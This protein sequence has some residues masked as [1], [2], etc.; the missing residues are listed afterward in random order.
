MIATPDVIIL[1]ADRID[2]AQGPLSPAEQALIAQAHPRRR[3]QFTAGRILAHRALARAGQPDK[4]LLAD[5][6][7]CPIWPDGIT[8]SIS[9][10]DT[11]CVA[12]VAPSAEVTSLGIDIEH[13][14]RVQP[15]LWPMLFTEREQATLAKLPETSQQIW[16]GCLFSIK[17]AFYKYQYPLTQRMVGFKDVE[18]EGTL[19]QA[20]ATICILKLIAPPLDAGLC[21]PSQHS[22]EKDRVCSLVYG[23]PGKSIIM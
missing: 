23:T 3:R 4:P 5:E 1:E 14:S 6:H 10:T 19:T 13:P 8:G 17:E 16:A 22:L 18:I 9:H 12:A 20:T 7:R 11:W 21:L 15:N 2:T